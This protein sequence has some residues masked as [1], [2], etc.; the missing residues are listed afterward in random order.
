[1]GIRVSKAVLIGVA[2]VLVCGGA[3]VWAISSKDEPTTVNVGNPESKAV[4]Y[5]Q[6]LAGAPPPLAKLYAKQDAIIAGGVDELHRKLA[7]VHGYPAVVNAWASWCGP[8]RF[9]FPHF[10]EAAAQVG[11]QVAF[12][13]VDT[14]DSDAAAR[15]YLDELPLPYPSISDP[16]QDIFDEYNIRFGLPATG[17]YDSDGKLV[18]V[19]QGPYESTADLLADIKRYAS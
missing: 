5:K 19:K 6:A 16:G 2:V 7:S 17:F 10:Q 4:D 3:V 1:M 8:C 11:K 15:D 14:D 12:L 18:F 13:G 9:E